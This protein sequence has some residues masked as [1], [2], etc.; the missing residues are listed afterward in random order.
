MC[1]YLSHNPDDIKVEDIQQESKELIHS[2]RILTLNVV[3]MI[4]KWREQ[5][6]YMYLLA[7]GEVAL[8]N[9]GPLPFIFQETNYL[10]KVSICM[11]IYIYI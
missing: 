8:Q 5:I 6:I 7:G 1:V 4:V 3:E 9:A 2:L 10:L 11:Y